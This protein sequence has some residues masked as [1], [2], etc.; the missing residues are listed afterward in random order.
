LVCLLLKGYRDREDRGHDG[1]QGGGNVKNN[2]TNRKTHRKAG[3]VN[4]AELSLM[5]G[6]LAGGLVVGLVAV[7]DAMVAELN[8]VARSIRAVS[9]SYHVPGTAGGSAVTYGSVYADTPS[10]AT[11]STW[12]R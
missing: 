12:E 5:S 3:F 11:P 2:V 10:D 6:I 7:R 8:G 9:Q 4:T 1:T